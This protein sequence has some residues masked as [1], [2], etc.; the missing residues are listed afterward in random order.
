[1]HPPPHIT[2]ALQRWRRVGRHGRDK[3]STSLTR[4]PCIYIRT[5]QHLHTY[6]AN[7]HLHT[8]TLN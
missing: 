5:L 8:Y 2:Y 4:Q 1:M 7:L 3:R 6:T